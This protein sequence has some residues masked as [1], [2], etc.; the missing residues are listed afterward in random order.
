[1][2]LKHYTSLECLY[3]ILESKRMRFTTL[4]NVD[5]KEEQWTSDFS[6]HG[7]HI[8]VCCFNVEEQENIGLWNMHKMNGE[9]VIIE[10]SR[11]P[12]E[13]FKYFS[14]KNGEEYIAYLDEK[15]SKIE[16]TDDEEKIYPK[17]YKDSANMGYGLHLP[18]LGKYKSMGWS[19]EK[20]YRYR[21]TA[22]Y[23]K[24]I[25]NKTVVIIDEIPFEY[26]DV[27]IDESA[28]KDIKIVIGY[29]VSKD[30]KDKLLEYIDDY[31]IKNGTN[32]VV[33]DS[34]YKN[35]VRK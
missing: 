4:K 19:F 31:N 2:K 32:I 1:M 23:Y 11:R 22:Y 28:L 24:K 29:N 7:Q 27:Q 33:K 15:I 3:K 6:N 21:M 30:D 18:L 16:Y 25:E 9:G 12:F 34:F 17:I 20:E 10:F 35:K 26:Y 8:F 14:K 5:D 13:M